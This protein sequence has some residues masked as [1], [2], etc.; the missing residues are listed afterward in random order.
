MRTSKERIEKWNHRR[1]VE[2]HEL[3]QLLIDCEMINRSTNII[4]LLERIIRRAESLR[5]YKRCERMN[6]IQFIQEQAFTSYAQ[7]KNQKTKEH[8]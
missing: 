6:F 2:L 4:Q 8:Q 7:K 3:E 1:C 5:S